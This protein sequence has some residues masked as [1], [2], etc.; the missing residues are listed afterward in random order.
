MARP[1]TRLTST[2]KLNRAIHDIELIVHQQ[3]TPTMRDALYDY[4]YG[5]LEQM[6]ERTRK[7]AMT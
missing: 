6:E 3:E 4:I 1:A 5:K 2:E 7:G